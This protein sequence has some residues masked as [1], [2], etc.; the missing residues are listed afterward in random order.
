M[1]RKSLNGTS[2]W[3]ALSL[4][5]V[6]LSTG[7]GGCDA[8]PMPSPG[9]PDRFKIFINGG[10]IR[11]GN[12]LE[13]LG[14]L[15]LKHTV[16]GTGVVV[17]KTPRGTVYA[18][19]SADGSFAGT[20]S[21][22]PGDR[23]QVTFRESLTGPESDPVDVVVPNYEPNRAPGLPSTDPRDA[24]IATIAS[25]TAST[26]DASGNTEITGKQLGANVFVS[27]GNLRSG[28]VVD[29]Q[30][31]KD[32][33]FKTTFPAVTGDSV[34]VIVRDPATGLTSPQTTLAVP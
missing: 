15:G 2:W 26:P 32:G 1:Q 34:L 4:V 5:A 19:A 8:D 33:A 31:D 22:L 11:P 23:I 13:L 12:P 21:G 6:L 18:T 20:V 14:I 16:Q 3:R 9:A 25:V 29:V 30:A 28:D 17:L 24:T 7:F 27:L 10:I